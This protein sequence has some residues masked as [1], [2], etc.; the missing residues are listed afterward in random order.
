MASPVAD[1]SPRSLLGYWADV[2]REWPARPSGWIVA[3]VVAFIAYVLT[4]TSLPVLLDGRPLTTRGELLGFLVAA[5]AA[6]AAGVAWALRL[7][8]APGEGGLAS[9]RRGGPRLQVTLLVS[10]TLL[11]AALS[12]LK[13]AFPREAALPLCL[14]SPEVPA[15]G[16]LWSPEGRGHPEVTRHENRLS[17]DAAAGRSWRLGY[18]NTLDFSLYGHPPETREGRRQL[19]RRA[20]ANPFEASVMLPRHLA[21]LLT[22]SFADSAGLVWFSVRARG[23]LTVTSADGVDRHVAARDLDVLHTGRFAVPQAALEGLT[24]VYRNFDCPEGPLAACAERLTFRTIPERAAV[25]DVRVVRS[26]GPRVPLGY[27]HVLWAR[28]SVPALAARSLEVV[29]FGLLALGAILAPVA[30]SLADRVRVAIREMGAREA[31]AMPAVAVAAAAL[32]Y[33]GVA[34]RPVGGRVYATLF[35]AG[36]SFWLT[37]PGT[38][39]LILGATRSPWRR[40]LGQVATRSGLALWLLPMLG[41]ALLE[42][43]RHVP[44]S[45][46]ATLWTPGDDHL[47]WASRAKD[48]LRDQTLS[49]AFA[50]IAKSTFPYQRA[51]GY[52]VLGEGERFTSI[53][54]GVAFLVTYAI[55]AYCMYLTCAA[56]VV[57]GPR[58]LRAVTVLLYPMLLFWLAQS[59]LAYGANHAARLFTE[60]P[61]WVAFTLSTAFLLR[62]AAGHFDGRLAAATGVMLAAAILGRSNLLVWAPVFIAATLSF[63]IDRPRAWA[64]ARRGILLP[65][66]VGLGLVAAHATVI[67]AWSRVGWYLGANT[68]LRA[69]MSVAS[70]FG[71]PLH[72]LFPRGTAILLAAFGALYFWVVWRERQAAGRWTA[73]P[74][75]WLLGFGGVLALCGYVLQVPLLPAPYYPR[76]IMPTYFFLVIFLPALLDRWSRLET[77]ADGRD[78]DRAPPLGEPR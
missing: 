32:A 48:V 14:R 76:M 37:L 34:G 9:P 20:R 19:L 63:T 8:G 60:G 11:L 66:V 54:V 10:A 53:A 25:L 27:G 59:L 64:M 50:S 57:R 78:G 3:S 41:Y 46:H 69:G 77:V 52:W 62:V 18:L 70:A 29:A 72:L 40:R 38:V 22:Q 61:A 6:G 21:A 31:L 49:P 74:V 45:D 2:S 68:S 30:G 47:T 7:R 67:G 73:G 71:Q 51:L 15:P 28:R 43:A 56:V 12:L 58:A 24:F 23:S 4:P 17:F 26:T 55:A 35:D 65:L 1:R 16:C 5:T 75:W 33:L 39:A 42:V 13:V 44:A 36:L